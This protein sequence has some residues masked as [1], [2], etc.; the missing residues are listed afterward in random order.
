[1]HGDQKEGAKGWLKGEQQDCGENQTIYGSLH[2]AHD[3]LASNKHYDFVRGMCNDTPCP[4]VW[5]KQFSLELHSMKCVVG[6]DKC[7]YH[8]TFPLCALND[9]TSI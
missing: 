7:N 9:M 8:K 1:M 5:H 4:K 2:K 3:F 6:S